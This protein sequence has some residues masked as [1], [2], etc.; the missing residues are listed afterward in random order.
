VVL[1]QQQRCYSFLWGCI[2][3]ILLLLLNSY[4]PL[5]TLASTQSSTI[6]SDLWPSPTSFLF[7]LYLSLLLCYLSIFCVIIIFF[8]FLTFWHKICFWKQ[9]NGHDSVKILKILILSVHVK[10]I[11]CSKENNICALQQNV[12]VIRRYPIH[13]SQ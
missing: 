11:H 9:N 7:P 12:P 6:P 4:S 10:S 3:V 2:K 5:W 13:I 1:G 8:L